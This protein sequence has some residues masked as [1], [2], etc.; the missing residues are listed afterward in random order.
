MRLYLDG[1]GTGK[2]THIS[3]FFDLK[4]KLDSLPRW[5]FKHKVSLSLLGKNTTIFVLI[6][7][8]THGDRCM[9]IC[10]NM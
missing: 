6:P 8:L 9:Q 1:D 4:G 3:V 5:S 7:N 2:G 10:D